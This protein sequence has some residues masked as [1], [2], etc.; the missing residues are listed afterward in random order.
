MQYAFNKDADFIFFLDCDEFIQVMDREQLE[1]KVFGLYDSAKAGSFHWINC[2][3]DILDRLLLKYNTG[4]WTNPDPPKFV[5][6]CVPRSLYKKYSGN[7]SRCQG[8]HQV[9]D[10]ESNFMSTTEIG[11]SIHVPVRSLEQLKVKAIQSS[12][13]HL[14]RPN[15]LPDENHQFFEM[16]KMISRGEMSD[17]FIRGCVYLYQNETKIIPISKSD[18]T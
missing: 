1:K 8:N 7:I 14:I 13:S 15:R 16:L 11:W 2:V 9:I 4:I 10:P 6:V 18:L 5:M 3:T 12:L 17:D